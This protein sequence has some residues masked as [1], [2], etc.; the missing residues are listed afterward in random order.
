[1]LVSLASLIITERFATAAATSNATNP[2]PTTITTKS[3][4]ITFN[5]NYLLNKLSN[6]LKL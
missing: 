3:N 6:I 5:L 2:P 4:Q 1:M